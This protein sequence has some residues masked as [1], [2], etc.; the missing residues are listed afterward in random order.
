VDGKKFSGNAFYRN[1][2][3]YYH[4]GTLLINSD[5]G[6]IS[7][8]L[9]VDT[10]KLKAK[11]VKSVKSRVCNLSEYR[12][13]LSID[14]MEE[15]MQKVFIDRADELKGK[16]G[17]ISRRELKVSDL[18]SAEIEKGRKRFSSFDWIFGK[19]IFFQ[20]ALSRRFDWGNIELLLDTDRGKIREV[21]VFS[22]AMDP[23][24][25]DGIK[26]A[27]IGINYRA[28]EMAEAICGIEVGEGNLGFPGQP[29]KKMMIRDIADMVEMEV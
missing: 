8:Y 16:A 28:D 25:A 19:P 27:L 7:K 21:S 10:D 2:E 1:G 14:M 26:T 3:Y 4:H 11:G 17:S 23:S 22:D 29:D 5:M 6:K 13:D 20:K 24:I 15:A 12:E 18:P 9:T